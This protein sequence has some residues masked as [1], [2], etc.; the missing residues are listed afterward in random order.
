MFINVEI[1]KGLDSVWQANNVR[2]IQVFA[3]L[4]AIVPEPTSLALLAMGGLFALVRRR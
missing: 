4:T 1:V 3:D 2:N